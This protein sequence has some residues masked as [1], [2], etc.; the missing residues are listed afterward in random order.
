MVHALKPNV[1]VCSVAL[2]VIVVN[3]VKVPHVGKC[4]DNQRAYLVAAAR[5]VSGVKGMRRRRNPIA[6]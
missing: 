6:S 3:S 1:I 4:L 5:I 2:S